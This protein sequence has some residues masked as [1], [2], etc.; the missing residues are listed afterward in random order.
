M[1]NFCLVLK[2]E[3]MCILLFYIHL[4]YTILSDLK[5]SKSSSRT[6]VL[7]VLLRGRRRRTCSR[8]ILYPGWLDC[9]SRADTF[10]GFGL[11]LKRVAVSS[12]TPCNGA[13]WPCKV[14]VFLAVGERR[15]Q[16]H[17]H[18]LPFRRVI[19]IMILYFIISSFIPVGFLKLVEW[20]IVINWYGLVFTSTNS[21]AWVSFCILKLQ[22]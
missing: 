2:Y 14:E 3:R 6:Y 9:A 19:N 13:I 8:A 17:G 22:K 18:G 16:N 12:R 1:P 21:R 4:I 20:I 10:Y 11:P 5:M 7:E 15:F